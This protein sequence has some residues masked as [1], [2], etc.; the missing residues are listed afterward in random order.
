MLGCIF[1]F[2]KSIQSLI[3]PGIGALIIGQ[4]AIEPGMSYFMSNDN[5]QEISLGVPPIWA[6]MGY[7]IKPPELHGADT[8]LI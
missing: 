2:K 4:E 1:S 6:S 7:S 5:V 3:Q 8:T